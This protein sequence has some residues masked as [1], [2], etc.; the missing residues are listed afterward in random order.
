MPAR[1]A[2]THTR[3]QATHTLRISSTTS[4]LGSMARRP[5]RASSCCPLPAAPRAATWGCLLALGRSRV[6]SSLCAG[7]Q[8]VQLAHA[9]GA[10]RAREN[11]GLCAVETV[12][13]GQQT[14][15]TRSS[16]AKLPF[17]TDGPK[18]AVVCALHREFVATYRALAP[19]KVRRRTCDRCTNNMRACGACTGMDGLY[20]FGSPARFNAHYCQAT[21]TGT[22]WSNLGG[23]LHFGL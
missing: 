23:W 1:I 21:Q 22:V 2:S 5:P 7:T 11:D 3:T 14:C 10:A 12:A 15:A 4:V 8:S 16:V 13:C 20:I 17:K 9:H 19:V 18:T 6:L